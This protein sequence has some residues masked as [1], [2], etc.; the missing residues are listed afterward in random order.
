MGS[1]KH[2]D[3][4]IKKAVRMKFTVMATAGLEQ[5]EWEADSGKIAAAA[6]IGYDNRKLSALPGGIVDTYCGCANPLTI[7]KIKPGEVVLD[8]GCG[9]GLDCFMVADI[10]GDEGK[11]IG[12][13]M[14]KEMV[15]KANMNAEK[16]RLHNVEFKRGEIEDIPLE[17]NSVDVIISNKSINLCPDKKKA[18]QESFRVLKPG[19]RLMVCD[20]L[21]REDIPDDV[22][23]DL[24]AWAMSHSSVI[25]EEEYLE[26]IKKAGFQDVQV[27]S[28]DMFEGLISARIKARKPA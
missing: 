7:D 14:T 19:G 20:V 15:R 24:D 21:S 25:K 13:D 10:V 12:L 22:R 2:S 17:D 5:C 27:L 1:L 11:V 16:L 9:G 4:E 28:K 3:E 23:D 8:L 26:S 6:H 18:F